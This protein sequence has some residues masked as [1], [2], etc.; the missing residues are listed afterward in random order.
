VL[1][2]T[3]SAESVAPRIGFVASAITTVCC[4]GLSFAISLASSIGATFLTQDATLKPL[5]AVMLGVTIIGT[6]L[7]L[8]R[9]R[10]PA[11][12][13]FV[14][15]GAVLVFAALYGPLDAGIGVSNATTGHGGHHAAHGAMNDAMTTSTGAH[16]GI[17][18]RALVWIGLATML[19][20]QLA[21]AVLVRRGARSRAPKPTKPA[22][23]TP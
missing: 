3:V 21:D 18:A 9:H 6:T 10:N 15:I 13:I 4:L 23:A 19:T 12:L 20:A 7:T 16:G 22:T 1:R 11:P 14:V 2:L 17:N 5:L 8:R